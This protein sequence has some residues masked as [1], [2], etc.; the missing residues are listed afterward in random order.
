MKTNPSNI[1]PTRFK[2]TSVLTTQK[3][4]VGSWNKYDES[5]PGTWVKPTVK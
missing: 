2:D 3:S 1:C 5:V 4:Q